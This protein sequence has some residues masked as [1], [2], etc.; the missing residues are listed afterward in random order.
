MR[1]IIELVPPKMHKFIFVCFLGLVNTLQSQENYPMSDIKLDMLIN[2]NAIIREHNTVVEI[3]D[4]DDIEIKT[5]RV[6]TVLNKAGENFIN[7]Y[8]NYDDGVT[9]LDQEA[10]I[11]DAK[12]NEIR[13]IKERDFKDKSNFQNFILFSDNRISYLDYTP[14]AYPYT[15]KYTSEV[16]RENSIF[17]PDWW[18]LEGYKLSV[19]YSSF[20]LENNIQVPIRYS[21][22]NLDSLNVISKN[23]DFEID[24][25]VKDIPAISYEQFS[26]SFESFAPR[27]LVALEEFHL[28]GIDGQSKDWKSFG[29]WQYDNLVA[30]RDDLPDAIVSKV[31]E[32]T[33]NVESTEEK[34]RIIYNYVQENTRYIAVMLGIGGWKPYAASEVH[35]LGYGDCKG[36]TNYT[37]SLLS[38][39][40]IESD[41]TIVYGG[42]K[43]DIDPDFTK[44]Q[45]NHVILSIPRKGKEDVWLEC[46]SQD[47]PFNYLGDFTD[48]RYVLK[49]KPDGGEIVKTKKYSSEDNVQV[50]NSSVILNEHGGFEVEIERSSSGV[51]YGDIY[52]IENQIEKDQK[53]YYREEFSYLQNIKFDNVSFQNDKRAIQFT[54]NLKFSGEQFCKNA[55][56][57][58]LLPLN[59]LR[60]FQ[61]EVSEDANRIRPVHIKRGESFKDSTSFQIPAGYSVEA[62][63]NSEKIETEFGEMNFD[64][65][66]MEKEGNTYLVVQR[67]IKI[68]DGEWSPSK[69]NDFQ[70]FIN[71]I[72]LTNNQ[73]AVL[74]AGNKT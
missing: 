60:N 70:N 39:Q 45:G 17:L 20:Q 74:L 12:G 41:Y 14:R 54:E 22:R 32:L 28:E 40:G 65:E 19:Q 63:P 47:T 25:S 51:P 29:K 73:K 24:Y 57:R 4:L 8:E 15:V 2:S 10:I 7:A 34:A 27:V 48:D 38:S 59:F 36:L 71:Q 43:R 42:N 21:E 66:V 62:K 46:T 3:N 26:P 18:P 58:L 61:F 23:S 5:T 69:F 1:G 35:R 16:R 49:L 67:F 55:G 53:K 9:I 13:K 72:H 37:R 6:I 11:Y 33:K 50:S 31:S 56:N 30:G 44:M 68:N 64:V 52:L